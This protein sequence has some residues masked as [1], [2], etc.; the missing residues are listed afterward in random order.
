MKIIISFDYEI[1]FKKN[2]INSNDYLIKNTNKIIALL[3]QRNIKT[4]FFIDAGYLYALDRQRD[5]FTN[6][7]DDYLNIIHQIMML[8]N[9]NHEIGFH[10][11]PHW[12][13]SYFLNGKWNMKLNRYKL[14]DYK[15]KE[16]ETI[17]H[18]YYEHLQRNLKKRVISHRSGGWCVE[19]FGLIKN[20][21]NNVGIKIEAT[22]FNGGVCSNKTHKYD[23]RGYP[24]KE[25]WRFTDTP[26]NE[27]KDGL[28]I[29]VPSTTSYIPNYYYWKIIIN[30]LLNITSDATSGEG[31]KPS[32]KEITRRIVFGNTIPV[33]IDKFK[34]SVLLKTFKEIE[35][36]NK[37]YFL[38]LGHPKSID[39]SSINDLNRFI[40][41][42]SSRGH[43]F[44][45][46]AAEFDN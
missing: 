27:N 34:S 16:I 36:T 37:E 30:K 15:Q 5:R 9:I 18:R 38:I 44:T 40:D 22:V 32:I 33:S 1:Y 43:T 39:E 17:I 3:E 7:K 23:F 25:Y 11:H 29:E 2:D 19:P 45:T 35:K 8:E 12:E 4:T 42:V 13:D 24:E 14:S 31:I 28:F 41:Y 10:T 46:Y 21:L 20:H 26:K 6:L